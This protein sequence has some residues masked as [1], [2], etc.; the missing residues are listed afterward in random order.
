MSQSLPSALAAAALTEDL[1]AGLEAALAHFGCK[2]GTVH[3]LRQGVLTLAAHTNI[4][5]AVAQAVATVPI[6][7][8]IA[9]LA[10]ERGEPVTICNL[11]TDASG[12]A[13]P[14]AKATGMEGA[15][16]VPMTA[17]G[18]LRGVL[19][20]AKSEPYDWHREEIAVLSAFGDA[21]AQ[22]CT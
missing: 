8:G 20:I 5:P 1:A 19:G 9:G 14:G 17:A 13:R 10:A 15:L 6:G 21:L 18:D 16:A 7:K 12:R 22:A 11:Q 3:L 4:P 2:S